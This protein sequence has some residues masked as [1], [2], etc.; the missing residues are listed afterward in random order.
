MM[1]S[2]N[3]VFPY[4][5]QK[6]TYATSKRLISNAPRIAPVASL[7]QRRDLAE[8]RRERRVETVDHRKDVDQVVGAGSVR[9]QGITEGGS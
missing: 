6:I 3:Q 2:A 7:E 8:E 1:S 9:V 5:S 4:D